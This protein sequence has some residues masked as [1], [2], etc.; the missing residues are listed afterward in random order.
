MRHSLPEPAD[1][2]VQ[3]RY[4]TAQRALTGQDQS[5]QGGADA[6]DCNEFRCNRRHTTILQRRRIARQTDQIEAKTLCI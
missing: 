6:N 1:L 5:R 3:L 2:V 4:F